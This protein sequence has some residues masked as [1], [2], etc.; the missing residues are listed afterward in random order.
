MG[1]FNIDLL[2]VAS[3]MHSQFNLTLMD[4]GLSYLGNTPTRVTLES[5]TQIDLVVYNALASTFIH[6]YK[7]LISGI[8]DHNILTFGYKKIK[9]VK[10][11]LKAITFKALKHGALPT[12]RL[13]ISNIGL[14]D[15]FNTSDKLVNDLM[16]KINAIIDTATIVK[17]CRV[18]PRNILGYH[19]NSLN[20]VI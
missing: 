13:A 7:N 6:S 18:V 2:N 19:L 10:P 5:S 11:I 17:T 8:S 12:I 1:D 15:S 20:C 14:I 9:S 4:Y 3:S 16:S